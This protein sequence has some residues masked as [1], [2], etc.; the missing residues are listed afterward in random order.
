M[1]AMVLKDPGFCEPSAAP[2]IIDLW[3]KEIFD[4]LNGRIIDASGSPERKSI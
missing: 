1:R 4:Y 3:K 2:E